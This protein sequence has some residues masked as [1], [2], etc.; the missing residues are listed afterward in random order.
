MN[1]IKPDITYYSDIKSIK[2]IE[3]SFRI[4]EEYPDYL[5][6]ES[7]LSGNPVETIFFPETTSDVSAIMRDI[8]KRGLSVC[9]SGARTGV[10]GGAV[11]TNVDCVISLSGMNEIL[12]FDNKS[13]RAQCGT[14]LDELNNY[15]SEKMPEIFYPVDPTETTS[16]IGGNVASNASGARTYYYGPTRNWV[17]AITVVLADGSVL[18]LKRGD[19]VAD[20]RRFR[21]QLPNQPETTFEF[22]NHKYPK[23]KNTAGFILT[24]NMD[25][26]DLFIGSEGILGIIT[27]VELRLIEK[28][29]NR[30][31]TI[32]WAESEKQ[33]VDLVADIRRSHILNMLAIEYF[34]PE[35]IGILKQ[36][37]MFEGSTSTIAKIPDD[38]IAAIFFDCVYKDD[39]ELA[40]IS[41]ELEIILNAQK[42]TLDNTWSG[43]ND[44]DLALMK[45]LRHILPETINMIIAERKKGNPNIHKLSTDFAIPDGMLESMLNIYHQKLGNTGIEY[46][47]CGHIGD[48][49]LHVNMLPKSEKELLL[50]HEL[51]IELAMDAV[52]LGGTIAAEHGIGRLKRHLMPIQYPPEMLDAMRELK[53]I[54]DPAGLLNPGVML[55]IDI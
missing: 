40:D 23:V 4:S 28:P 9:V 12:D 36:R 19:V 39:S 25:A 45:Q 34:S 11:A 42:L 2:Y 8:H 51:Y 50:A 41:D 55:P 17:N 54:F 27:E 10:V 29:S 35:A 18:D 1:L 38:A 14:T 48:N 37:R 6:D 43:M 20:G 24:E 22:P 33:S 15:I 46:V 16:S 7:R 5:V 3:G 13:I 26:I 31:Y 21:I 44:S 53:N 52:R 47:S 32:I 30:L 49:H